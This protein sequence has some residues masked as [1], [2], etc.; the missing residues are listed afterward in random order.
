MERPA[1]VTVL[2][3]LQ[4]IGAGM[5][6]IFGLLMLVG[7]PF[8][9]AMIGSRMNGAEGSS[10]V[11]GMGA[12]IG[13]VGGV[14]CL[15]MAALYGVVGW[16]MWGLKNWARMV[17]IVLAAIGG[18]L[19][20]LGMMGSLVHFHIFAVLWHMIWIGVN[21]VIIWYLLQPQVKAAFEGP[22]PQLRAAGM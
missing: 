5:C 11:A 20:A 2:A 21:A 6:V 16:G 8:V 19:Q 9:A 15:I 17:T 4:F 18:L 14:F 13:V 10:A 3:I 1:G 7:G 22:Q 12:V